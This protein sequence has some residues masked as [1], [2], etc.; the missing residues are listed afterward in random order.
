[1]PYL[2]HRK[3]S[4]IHRHWIC[5]HENGGLWVLVFVA[6]DHSLNGPLCALW[7]LWVHMDAVRIPWP[8]GE[9][10]EHFQDACLLMRRVAECQR[11]SRFLSWP[12]VVQ[13]WSKNVNGFMIGITVLERVLLVWYGRQSSYR[14]PLIGCSWVVWICLHS[15]RGHHATKE[16]PVMV[17]LVVPLH[18]IVIEELLRPPKPKQYPWVLFK[19]SASD[20]NFV[21]F[22]LSSSLP[23][24]A[25]TP[26]STWEAN[27]D[28][29]SSSDAIALG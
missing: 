15:Q 3:V 9:H 13:V 11:G 19:I 6:L 18:Q 21:A 29:V 10:E 16:Q 4:P 2:Q 8:E 7:C 5:S 24:E 20:R 23:N 27:L 22:V 28:S 17:W 26:Q 14:A 12:G 1:M 25:F